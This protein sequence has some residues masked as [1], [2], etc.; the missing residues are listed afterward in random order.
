MWIRCGCVFARMP[1][2]RSRRGRSVDDDDDD[3]DDGGGGGDEDEDG[4]VNEHLRG[5]KTDPASAPK[6]M[7]VVANVAAAV[8]LFDKTGTLEH[9]RDNFLDT[10]MT[11]AKSTLAAQSLTHLECALVLADPRG[12]FKGKATRQLERLMQT[13]S[14][15]ELVQRFSRGDFKH[16]GPGIL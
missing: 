12:D 15:H 4:M 1:S 3:D 10:L 5:Q 16:D 2:H 6:K 8:A 11:I 13:T 7:K 9:K 14:F